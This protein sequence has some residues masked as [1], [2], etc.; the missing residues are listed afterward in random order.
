ML[1]GRCKKNQATKTYEQI[2]RGKNTVEYFC[3][4]CYHQLFVVA[5]AE[6]DDSPDI[7]PYCGMGIE[8]LKKHRLVGCAKCYQT[9]AATLNTMIVK[10]QGGAAHCGKKPQGGDYERLARRTGELKTI[11]NKLNAEKD[12]VAAR[13]YTERLSALQEGFE[14]EDYV[15]R[16]HP[17]SFKQP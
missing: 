1:C 11:V 7:C 12:F 16:K 2:K 8:E 14:E 10:M 15:W 17:L 3:L 6:T 9:F 4:D 13:A 5:D